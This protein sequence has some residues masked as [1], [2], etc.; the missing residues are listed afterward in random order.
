MMKRVDELFEKVSM[1]TFVVRGGLDKVVCNDKIEQ[2]YESMPA[3]ADKLM[4]TMDEADH[5]ILLDQEHCGMMLNDVMNW[6]DL[7]TRSSNDQQ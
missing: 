2:F 4:L 5:N 6:L 1:P 3:D 7:R